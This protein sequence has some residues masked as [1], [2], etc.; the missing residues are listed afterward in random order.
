MLIAFLSANRSESWDNDC[1]TYPPGLSAALCSHVHDRGQYCYLVRLPYVRKSYYKI[2]GGSSVPF[3]VISQLTTA[4]NA[5]PEERP[6]T[7]ETRQTRHAT[8]PLSG[9]YKMARFLLI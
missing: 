8:A 6:T 4:H 5:K 7:T 1:Y 9:A 2:F 3:R